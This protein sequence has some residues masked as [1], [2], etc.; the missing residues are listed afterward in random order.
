MSLHSPS[1]VLRSSARTLRGLVVIWALVGYPHIARPA[2]LP[3][4][5]VSA[6][7]RVKQIVAHRGA[8]SERP[9]CTLA[10]IHRAIEVGAT[11]IEMDVRT[12]K[13]GGLFLLHDKTLDRTTN[14]T[15]RASKLSIKQLKQLD[16]GS[17]FDRAYKDERIPTLREALQICRD[18]IDLLLDLK[19]KGDPYAKAVAEEV[20]RYGDPART[21]IGV[22]SVEWDRLILER[23]EKRVTTPYGRIRVKIIRGGGDGVMVSPE[24]DDCKAAARRKGVSLKEVIRSADAAGRSD[25]GELS[26]ERRLPERA[27]LFRQARFHQCPPMA[28]DVH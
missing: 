15:G 7:A 6:A 20:R 27:G 12:S 10:A 14:G 22:R 5:I 24:Y 19:E 2:E 21:I 9:E 8:S 28:N 4:E 16:A 26:A 17:W 18:K 1:C 13:D 23:Q 11:A 25:R 3:R